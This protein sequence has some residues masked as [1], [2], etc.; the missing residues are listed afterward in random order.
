MLK[1]NNKG[2]KIFSM[3]GATPERCLYFREITLCF[4]WLTLNYFLPSGV[5]PN[6]TMFHSNGVNSCL[7]TSETVARRWCSV[8]KVFLKT[9]PNSQE[10]TC[11]MPEACNFIKTESLA[12]MFS[13][14]FCEICKNT[15][16]C[17]TSPVVACLTSMAS[18]RPS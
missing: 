3:T 9:S 5:Y 13:C 8:K 15:F 14:E 16:F 10:N 6:I 12:Q 1:V 4:L 17:R 2:T 11:A 7:F 18:L